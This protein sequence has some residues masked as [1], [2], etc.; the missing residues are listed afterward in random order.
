MTDICAICRETLD[1]NSQV[2]MLPEC[3]HKF[4][5][6]CI[7]H[8]FRYGRQTCPLCNN[9][10]AGSQPAYTS[11][12][13]KLKHLRRYSLTRECSPFIKQ[14]F[15]LLRRHESRQKQIILLYK[16]KIDEFVGTAKEFR[17]LE[18]ERDIKLRKVNENIRI[19]KQIICEIPIELLILVTRVQVPQYPPPLALPDNPVPNNPVPNNPVPDQNLIQDQNDV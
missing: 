11:R 2:F 19:Q 16:K 10:G 18:S 5:T 7:V 9:T 14:Q 4:H 12:F 15:K 6:E 3:E 17:K 13:I 1:D 8:W